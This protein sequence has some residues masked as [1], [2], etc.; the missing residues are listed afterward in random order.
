MSYYLPLKYPVQYLL[1]PPEASHP[2]EVG[3]AGED[4]G[5]V[6][7]ADGRETLDTE[8]NICWNGI[9]EKNKTIQA[10]Q[11]PQKEIFIISFLFPKKDS[12]FFKL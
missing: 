11:M 3:E 4:E 7:P 10:R 6:S 2:H 12:T 9:M 5:E 1:W 8:V